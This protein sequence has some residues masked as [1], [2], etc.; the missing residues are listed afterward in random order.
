MYLKLM[1]VLQKNGFRLSFAQVLFWRMLFPCQFGMWVQGWFHSCCPWPS[2]TEQ[3]QVPLWIHAWGLLKNWLTLLGWTSSHQM[4]R[5]CFSVLSWGWGKEGVCKWD[6][7]LWGVAVVR[8][9][10]CTS[11]PLVVLTCTTALPLRCDLVC[12]IKF[13]VFYFTGW[14]K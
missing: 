4:G 9:L 1:L 14:T 3:P 7:M 2:G 10:T 11:L 6:L 12:V 8:V 5:T 13:C